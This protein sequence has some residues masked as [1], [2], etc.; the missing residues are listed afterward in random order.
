VNL[1]GFSVIHESNLE[2][3]STY[4]LKTRFGTGYVKALE[5]GLDGWQVELQPDAAFSTPSLKKLRGGSLMLVPNG[6]GTWY[7]PQA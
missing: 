6:T 5:S 2:K 3:G 4:Y 1:Q 7:E